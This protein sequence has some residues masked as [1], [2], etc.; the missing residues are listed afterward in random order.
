MKI[1]ATIFF[2]CISFLLTAQSPAKILYFNQYLEAADSSSATIKGWM[3]QENQR[4]KVTLRNIKSNAVLMQGYF[5]DTEM[6]IA[7]GI[8]EFWYEDGVKKSEELYTNGKPHGTWKTWDEDGRLSDTSLYLSGRQI[9]LVRWSFYENDSLKMNQFVDLPNKKSHVK[10]YYEEGG[11]KDDVEFFDD[12]EIGRKSYY[13]NGQLKLDSKKDKK[14]KQTYIK[15]FSETGEEISEKEYQ[16]QLQQQQQKIRERFAALIP[17]FKSGELGFQMYLTQNLKIPQRVIRENTDI[18]E[19]KITFSLNQHGRAHNIVVD[20]VND[21]EFMDVIT[22]FFETI[23]SW[24][25]KGLD[26]YGPLTYKIKF[27]H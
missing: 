23:P 3:V 22:K 17:E 24:D 1:F 16:K 18:D 20:G 14:G 26:K 4:W 12:K 6:Q 19:V 8:L 7:D 9:I 25:M 21:P 2:S 15:R 10:Y 5:L 11:I 27:I 13:A